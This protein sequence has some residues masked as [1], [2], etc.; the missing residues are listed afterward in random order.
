[1]RGKSMIFVGGLIVVIG[2]IFLLNNLGLTSIELGDLVVTYWPIILILWGFDVM[3]Q[4]FVNKDS[5]NGEKTI[6]ASSIITGL[7]LLAIGL[8]ILGRNLELFD[9]DL[10][11]L[12]NVFWPLVVIFIGWILIRGAKNMSG[13]GGTHWAVM[14]GLE[15]KNKGWKLDDSNVY[16]V[17]G[18][19]DMDI[20]V[21]EFPERQVDL[22]LMVIMGGIDIRVPRDGTVISEGTA[23]LGGVTFLQEEAGG[24]I[25]NKQTT[26]IGDPESQKKLVIKALAVLGG[27]E[28]KH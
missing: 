19:V 24:I 12:W 21:A 8:L 28:V 2:F 27:I 14:S 7:T 3:G 9:F 22:N 18:G 20:T 13:S 25:A 17:M 26:Y 11:I 10:S 16:A 1:M 15:F 23:V 6:Y 5:R 4:E